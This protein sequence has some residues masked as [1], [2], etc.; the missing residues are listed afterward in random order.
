[1]GYFLVILVHILCAIVFVGYVFFDVCIYP[2]AKR[3]CDEELLKKVK[4]A[5]AKGGA[6][7][8]GSA[9]VLLLLSGVYL[10]SNY[11]GGELGYLNSGFQVI[12]WIKMFLLILMCF[13]TIISVFFVFV[14]KRQ[15]PFGKY[16][17]LIGLVLCIM[18]VICAKA[19]VLLNF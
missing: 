7:V 10:A 8:F 9:F 3:Y 11:I 15:D 17:H 13:I 16:S 2:M 5:Y 4:S 18:I 6:K 1:M 14:L 12:F 19:M